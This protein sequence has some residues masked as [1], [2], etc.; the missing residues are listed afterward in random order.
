MEK[1]ANENEDSEQIIKLVEAVTPLAKVLGPI[2]EKHEEK[3]APIIRRQQWM[4]FTI[5][6]VLALLI[7]GLTFLGKID[8]SA[9]TG[10]LGAIV[11]YVFG[12]IYAKREKG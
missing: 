4:N 5:M 7:G 12:Y 9:A 10:L 3:K 1:K 2:F 8:G 11:G 6:I